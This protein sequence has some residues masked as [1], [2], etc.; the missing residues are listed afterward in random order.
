MKRYVVVLALISFSAA[1]PAFAAG[2]ICG[3][4]LEG[5]WDVQANAQPFERFIDSSP[6]EIKDLVGSTA[7]FTKSYIRVGRFRCDSPKFFDTLVPADGT[8][9]SLYTGR[10]AYLTRNMECKKGSMLDL[11][12]GEDCNTIHVFAGHREAFELRRRRGRH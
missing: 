1:S 12:I 2:A 10:S 7:T 5:Q 6:E 8:G 4:S 9:N 3:Q 11:I